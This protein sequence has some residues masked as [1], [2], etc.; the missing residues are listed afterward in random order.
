MKMII[1]LFDHSV[2]SFPDGSKEEVLACHMKKEGKIVSTE[3][4]ATPLSN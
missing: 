4:G 2:L 1:F 3:T